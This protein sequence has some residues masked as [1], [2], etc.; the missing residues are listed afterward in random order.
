MVSGAWTYYQ[1]VVPTGKLV[2]EPGQLVRHGH[3]ANSVHGLLDIGRTLQ[4][5][6]GRVIIV[7]QLRR[8]FRELPLAS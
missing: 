8:Q 1:E 4:R 7:G 2:A 5:P 3:R 6:D